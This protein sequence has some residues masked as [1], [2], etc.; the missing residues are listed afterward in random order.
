MRQGAYPMRR[1]KPVYPP[2]WKEFS[3]SI[4]YGRAQEQC[5]CVGSCGLHCRHGP[6]RCVERNHMPA[7]GAKGRIVLTVAHLCICD[8]PCVIAEHVLA[9]C[10]RCHLRVDMN[11]H[12]QHRADT[13]DKQYMEAGQIVLFDM[14]HLPRREVL[15]PNGQRLISSEQE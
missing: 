11:L 15:L 3:R 5:E 1:A 10:Q 9:L 4:R 14:S 12:R 2:N 7:Q 8:P 13:L 6:R